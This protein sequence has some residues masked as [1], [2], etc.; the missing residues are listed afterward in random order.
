MAQYVLPKEQK[1]EISL[2]RRRIGNHSITHSYLLFQIRMLLCSVCI[3][4]LTVRHILLEWFQHNYLRRQLDLSEFLQDLLVNKE[5]TIIFLFHIFHHFRPPQSPY[6]VPLAF[7]AVQ[8][9]EI[10]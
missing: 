5:A 8:V 1:R 9:M 4:Q 6:H 3:T 10:K 7:V 2:Y